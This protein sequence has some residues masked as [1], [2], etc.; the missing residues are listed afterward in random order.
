VVPGTPD[1]AAAHDDESPPWYR[2]RF[3]RRQ[4]PQVAIPFVVGLLCFAVAHVTRSNTASLVGIGL[5]L[6]GVLVGWWA[7][8]GFY[9][10][11][12][13]ERKRRGQLP[14]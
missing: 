6:V 8:V 14:E 1:R 5:M 3:T 9:R 11:D 10:E 13:A 7:V 2:R 4:R 12:R